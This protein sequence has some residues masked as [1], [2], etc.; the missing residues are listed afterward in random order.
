MSLRKIAGLLAAF[1]L[2][3]GLIG[4]GVGAAFT[5]T[6]TAAQSITV[7]TLSCQISAASGP[8]SFS[9]I[10]SHTLSYTAPLITAS[11]GSA[12]FSFTV[13][14]NGGIPEAVSV[15]AGPISEL[16]SYVVGPFSAP[17]PVPTGATVLA[18]NGDTV[19][20]TAGLSWAGLT[21]ADM[22]QTVSVTYTVSCGEVPPLGVAFSSLSHGPS[23]WITDTISG[24]GMTP[25]AT[26]QV[27]YSFGGWGI[28]S[29]SWGWT[30]PTAA[31][32]GTFTVSFTEDCT[33]PTTPVQQNPGDPRGPAYATDQAVTVWAT[34]GTHSAAGTG[35]LVCSQPHQ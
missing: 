31:A 4:G 6:A 10:G 14:N 21:N 18:N 19:A 16:P 9:G 23:N 29:A 25:G 7:A 24:T 32:N 12:P 11:T 2:A 33:S 13:Q 35:V 5:D 26:V 30:D 20:Y 8:G 22:G 28:I 27:S 15:S 1:G 34:D 17:A 3:L